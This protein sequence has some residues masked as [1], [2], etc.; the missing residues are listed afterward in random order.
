M[1]SPSDSNFDKN[2]EYSDIEKL[3]KP[4]DKVCAPDKIFEDGSCYTLQSLILIAKAY[5]QE[6]PHDKI[7][8][9][10]TIETLY[11]NKYKRFLVRVLSKKLK[12]ECNDQKC[13]T[14]RSFIMNIAK[15]NREEIE[16][17]TFRPSG[18]SGKFE[19]L[20]TL[21]IDEVMKQYENKYDDFKFL[22]TVPV[23]FDDLSNLGIQNL[24]FN[25]LIQNNK[26][27]IGLVINLDE[28]YKSG[29]HWVAL[30]SNLKSGY[31]YFFDSYGMRPDKRIRAFMIRISKFIKENSGIKKPIV[32]YNR[33]RHQFKNSECGVYS[34]NFIVR[35]LDGE[36][37][38]EICE[39]KV[40]DDKINKFREEYFTKK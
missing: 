10:N 39:S 19:W 21:H 28:H 16:K 22:G 13:W 30:F 26:I 37:F 32:D 18:P 24:N 31:V 12:D 8:L 5:N 17:Y 7:K 23:D 38:E 6:N 27:K 29:S 40:P 20:N 1:K 4:N 9:N 15:T 14:Q 25:E 34:I 3:I 2:S 35:M 36:T 33:I 11:P